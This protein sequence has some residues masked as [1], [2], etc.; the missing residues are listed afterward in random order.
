MPKFIAQLLT[1]LTV[2][3]LLLTQCSAVP[4]RPQFG[5]FPAEIKIVLPTFPEEA[6]W[7]RIRRDDDIQP[8]FA[9]SIDNS[10]IVLDKVDH[11]QYPWW[12]SNSPYRLSGR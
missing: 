9:N 1:L 12:Q 10:P 5:I 11:K 6:V 7:N 4:L 3:I 2:L 8:D